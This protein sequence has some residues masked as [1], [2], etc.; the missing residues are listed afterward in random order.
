VLTEPENHTP[1]TYLFHR[2]DP[3]QPEDPVVPGDLAITSPS[4][5]PLEFAADDPA[6]PST[7]RR[8]AFA[9]W[10]TSGKHPLVT[11]VLVNRVWMHHFGR[12]LVGTPSDFGTVGE[13]PTHP[14]L[15]DWL[16]T[17]FVARGWSMKA[18][19][20]LIMTSSAYRQSSQRD[21]AKE[22]IDPDNTFYWHM[23]VQ[24]LEAEAIRDSILAASGVLNIE[25]FGP[26]VPV[27]EDA[28]G[29][30]VVGVDKKGA[31]NTP[32]KEVPLGS[33]A[34]RRSVYIQVRRSEPL[35][36]LTAFDAPVME[37][38][39]DR[40]PSS[41]VAP[42]A[43]MLMNSNF[44]LEQSALFARRLR[45]EAGDDPRA[46]IALAWH[47]AYTRAPTDAEIE[48][49]LAFL[50]HQTEQ[51]NQRG[52]AAEGKKGQATSADQQL[53][54]LTNLCQVLLSSNEFLYVD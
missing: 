2:G 17:E 3:H 24:R 33:D 44:I 27:K 8:L 29:Q 51:L 23:P 12:G 20:K 18:L 13:R 1:V 15:L 40:R 7:G 32:G 48:Q 36:V 19:H 39:C 37:T 41:T 16:A 50:T 30:I 43:L 22:A 38:N 45:R 10:I 14:E 49:S 46:Q 47:L 21:A 54:A 34:F 53:Q 42:Q 9:R 11:R 52:A 28:V 5:G 4:A 26:P 25:M 35:A 6:L 31:S